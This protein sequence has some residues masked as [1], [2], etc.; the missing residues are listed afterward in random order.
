MFGCESAAT[1]LASRSKRDSASGSRASRPRR[2]RAACR[3]RDRPRPCLPRRGTPRRHT[4]RYECRRSVAWRT[5]LLEMRVSAKS[6][7]GS[8]GAER[9]ARRLAFVGSAGSLA[10][11]AVARR[12]TAATAFR[13]KPEATNLETNLRGFRLQAEGCVRP[14]RTPRTRDA[15]RDPISS[16]KSVADTSRTESARTPARR[17]TPSGPARTADRTPGTAPCRDAVPA[18]TTRSSP[19]SS[20]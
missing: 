1:A 19:S 9:F 15:N 7:V 3:A 18:P 6:S 20:S 2:D 17:R 13:L 4:D 12:F 14:A 10:C 5:K 16:R 11:R 8:V